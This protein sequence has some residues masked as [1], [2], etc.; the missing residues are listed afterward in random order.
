MEKIRWSVGVLDGVFR[1]VIVHPEEAP[2]QLR[3]LSLLLE[4]Q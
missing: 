3:A 1:A 2:E 4:S